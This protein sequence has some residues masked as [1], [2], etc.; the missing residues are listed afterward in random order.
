MVPQSI[1]S[2]VCVGGAAGKLTG[3]ATLNP[4]CCNGL[5]WRAIGV[6]VKG[7][8]V[9]GEMGEPPMPYEVPDVE[10]EQPLIW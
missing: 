5:F 10:A 8:T 3:T 2:V 9:L 4:S 1:V 7:I 6:T